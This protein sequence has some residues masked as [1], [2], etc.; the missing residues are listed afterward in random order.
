VYTP[1]QQD[2][3]RVSEEILEELLAVVDVE[4]ECERTE[5]G[6]QREASHE[7]MKCVVLKK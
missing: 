1:T 2:D 4:L 3:P 6:R 7:V 5:A